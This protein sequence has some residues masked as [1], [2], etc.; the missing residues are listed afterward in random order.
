VIIVIIFLLIVLAVCSFLEVSFS[1]LNV[2]RIKKMA[3][4]KNKKAKLF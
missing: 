3:D 1:G 4:N 2:I